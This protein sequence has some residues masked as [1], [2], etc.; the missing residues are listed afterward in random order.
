[1]LGER[2]GHA[3]SHAPRSGKGF[4]VMFLD[5]DR[6]KSIN[7]SLGHLFGDQVLQ[8][9]ATRLGRCLRSSDT[10][11]RLGGD[12]FVIHLHDAGRDAADGFSL[13]VEQHWWGHRATKPTWLYVCG[14]EPGDVPA[15]PLTLTEATH[16][17]ARD[18][19]GNG[20]NRTKPHCTHAEREA[21]PPAFAAW[22]VE[23]ARRCSKH[24]AAG[25]RPLPAGEKP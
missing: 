25:E 2:V 12:E 5:L 11:C 10:L 3:I 22:L 24:N 4:A 20:R 7:D 23:L 19:R 13:A 17:V 6:F 9:V 21:T 16:V 1:M 8:E 18:R 15:M 14:C